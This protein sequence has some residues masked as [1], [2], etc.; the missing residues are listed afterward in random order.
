[1]S[2]VWMIFA[3]CGW[4]LTFWLPGSVPDLLRL[5]VVVVSACITVIL[6]LGAL[7]DTHALGAGKGV[8]GAGF[9]VVILYLGFYILAAALAFT[10]MEDEVARYR[11]PGL[12]IARNAPLIF[13]GSTAAGAI[14]LALGAILRLQEDYLRR[15]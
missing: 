10:L 4:G 5:A 13:G 8:L 1:M 11:G 14:L 6:P 7:R 15:R 9:G 3:I 12:V 2:L